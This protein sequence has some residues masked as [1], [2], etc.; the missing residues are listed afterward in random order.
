MISERT[1]NKTC[2]RVMDGILKPEVQIDI[3]L[4]KEEFQVESKATKNGETS[5]TRK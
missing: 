5:T 3:K 4:L 1:N 2:K